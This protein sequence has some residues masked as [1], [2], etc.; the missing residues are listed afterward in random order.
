MAA[1]QIYNMLKEYKGAGRVKMYGL[2]SAAASVVAMAGDSVL[3]SAVSLMLI[4]NP[5]T[6]AA[7]D[8]AEMRKTG[9]MLDE[10]KESIINAYEM[11]CGLGRRELSKLMDAEH[12]MNAKEALALGFIDGILYRDE[13]DTKDAMVAAPAAYIG[14]LPM[15]IQNS[16]MEK[17][18]AKCQIS[19]PTAP[20]GHS[21]DDLMA[22]L[23]LIKNYI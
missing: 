16:I 18:A 2:A 20:L 23:H 17:I 1:A 15:Q 22:R 7:G 19:K 8:A 6:I 13:N 3:I 5:S 10:V 14:C 9:Q 12:T 21:C 4:H 11:K